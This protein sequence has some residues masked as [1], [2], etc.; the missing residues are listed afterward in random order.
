M[1][2]SP[3]EVKKALKKYAIVGGILFVGTILTVLV[4]VV[5]EFDRGAHGFDTFDL[6]LGLT[7]ATIKVT[8]VCYFFMHLNHEKPWVYWL[9]GFGLFFAAWMAF[10]IFLADGD[11]I[12]YDKFEDGGQ[13][14]EVITE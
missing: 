12:H 3:E 1:A 10:L 9:F 2:D 6:V 4:A 14:V 7:I 8:L 11:P 13:T 5:P